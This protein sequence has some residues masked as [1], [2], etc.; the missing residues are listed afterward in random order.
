[1]QRHG[2]YVAGLSGR[3]RLSVTIDGAHVDGSPFT[4]DVPPEAAAPDVRPRSPTAPLRLKTAPDW[5]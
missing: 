3:Y 2:T 4:V 1:M 5:W